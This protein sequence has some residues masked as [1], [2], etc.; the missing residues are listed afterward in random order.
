VVVY[1]DE[2]VQQTV[3]PLREGDEQKLKRGRRNSEIE[4]IALYNNNVSGF[5]CWG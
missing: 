2:S 4:Q 5:A 1:V 3:K